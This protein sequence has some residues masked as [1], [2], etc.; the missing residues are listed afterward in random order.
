MCRESL[1]AFALAGGGLNQTMPAALSVVWPF[2]S[3]QSMIFNKEPFLF[4]IIPSQTKW[5]PW[6]IH[7]EWCGLTCVD[8]AGNCEK[9]GSRTQ[10]PSHVAAGR[11]R[12]RGQWAG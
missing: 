1:L 10:R 12:T 6:E 3:A 8:L 7:G 4:A 2:V 9:L 11:M 5:P